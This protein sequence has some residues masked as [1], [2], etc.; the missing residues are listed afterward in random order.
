MKKREITATG[1]INQ[2]GELAMYMGEIKEFFRMHK[3]A[4]VF[5]RFSIAKPGTSE[6]LK[7]YYYNCVVPT[8]QQAI[9]DKG[10]RMTEAKTEEYIR[11]LSPIMYEQIPNVDTG[12]YETRIKEISELSNAELVEHIETIKQYCAENLNVY[13]EDPQSI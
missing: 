2:S 1:T 6:A 13:I 3:G 7:G 12:F 10:E 11:E 9:W 8:F 4:R 5:A